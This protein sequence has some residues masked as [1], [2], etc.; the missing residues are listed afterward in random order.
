[1]KLYHY[2]LLFIILYSSCTYYPY[3]KIVSEYDKFKN[4]HRKHI[5]FVITGK[6][7]TSNYGKLRSNIVFNVRFDESISTEGVRSVTMDI[8]SD[9]MPEMYIDS[10]IYFKSN[11]ETL[12]I[13]LDELKESAYIN[14][15]ASSTTSTNT[16]TA[17]KNEPVADSDKKKE[18]VETSTNV[19]VTNTL[20]EYTRKKVNV[21]WNINEQVI[22]FVTNSQ[23]FSM[24]IY[25]NNQPYEL[26]L[27][28]V[29]V[30]QLR[31]FFY[32]KLQ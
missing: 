8:G 1:M 23:T 24:G 5:S 16:T 26:Q 31:N 19:N 18:T 28:T 25:V 21:R 9:L 29:Q 13:N 11:I 10:T 3:G 14:K 27:T 22:K 20:N 7:T 32:T 6:S 17:V 4:E 12:A 2:S 15:V 30:Q